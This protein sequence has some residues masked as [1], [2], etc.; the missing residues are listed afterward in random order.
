PKRTKDE[1]RATYTALRPIA[2]ELGL[3][4][5]EEDPTRQRNLALIAQIETAVENRTAQYNRGASGTDLKSRLERAHE[6]IG[7]LSRER[8]VVQSQLREIQGKYREA[9]ATIARQESEFAESQADLVRAR[10]AGPKMGRRIGDLTLQIRKG[11]A[12]SETVTK[13]QASIDS[14]KGE[15]ES[16]QRKSDAAEEQ[17]RAVEQ[18]RNRLLLELGNVKHRDDAPAGTLSHDEFAEVWVEYEETVSMLRKKVRDAEF[19]GNGFQNTNTVLH[20]SI[21]DL[22]RTRT[23]L[24]GRVTKLDNKNTEI[25]KAHEDLERRL[26]SALVALA[27]LEEEQRQGRP[28]TGEVTTSS[29]QKVTY[30]PRAEVRPDA[31]AYALGINNNRRSFKKSIEA[32]LDE[33]SVSY[34][35]P[36]DKVRFFSYE[37]LRP[38]VDSLAEKIVRKDGSNASGREV[39]EI[40]DEYCTSKDDPRWS[41][42]TW[43]FG[44][45]VAI[46]DLS[47]AYRITD[48]AAGR[49]L[50]KN[51]FVSTEERREGTSLTKLFTWSQKMRRAFG[52]RKHTDRDPRLPQ[53]V[54]V[55]DAFVD[56]AV[57]TRYETEIANLQT[58]V[59]ELEEKLEEGRVTYK[60]E[61]ANLERHIAALRGGE[62]HLTFDPEA[63][64]RVSYIPAVLDIWSGQ[65]LKDLRAVIESLDITTH[66]TSG[67]GGKAWEYGDVREYMPQILEAL[68]IPESEWETARDT[69]DRYF[70][71][72]EDERWSPELWEEGK[73]IQAKDLARAYRMSPDGASNVLNGKGVTSS[74]T[75]TRGIITTRIYAWSDTIKDIFEKRKMGDPNAPKLPRKI[76]VTVEEGSNVAEEVLSELDDVRQELRD[77]KET[78]ETRLAEQVER[79]TELEAVIAQYEAEPVAHETRRLVYGKEAE[80]NTYVLV[81]LGFGRDKNVSAYSG[82]MTRALTEGLDFQGRTVQ[83]GGKVWRY[84]VIRKELDAIAAVLSDGE[85]GLTL[86][87]GAL[88][89]LD[90]FFT[91]KEDPRWSPS[92]WEDGKELESHELALAYMLSGSGISNVLKKA[93]ITASRIERKG[94]AKCHF[95]TWDERMRNA[96]ENRRKDGNR[97]KP[98]EERWEVVEPVEGRELATLQ[99]ELNQL[100]TAYRELETHVASEEPAHLPETADEALGIALRMR[101]G[102]ETPAYIARFQEILPDGITKRLADLLKG[103]RDY[104]FK[105]IASTDEIQN[106]NLNVFAFDSV[107]ELYEDI[108]EEKPT[109][110]TTAPNLPGMDTL[111]VVFSQWMEMDGRRKENVKS[112]RIVKKYLNAGENED[113]ARKILWDTMTEPYDQAQ[114]VIKSAQLNYAKL[115]ENVTVPS[116]QD[117]TFH[118]YVAEQTHDDTHTLSIFLPFN[119]QDRQSKLATAARLSLYEMLP[120]QA[121]EWKD[122]DTP[123]ASPIQLHYHGK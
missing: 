35:E 49:V 97:P 71:G 105:Q 112:A 106:I 1:I 61:V 78:Y 57:V 2:T 33:L 10:E 118:V 80:A 53:E 47:L 65:R 9:E 34:R 114:S 28:A 21:A 36:L 120:E 77:S 86:A 58:T 4:I 66:K 5:V 63:R 43:E 68:R 123:N 88:A 79:I 19:T 51:K 119:E 73:E 104:V 56:D 14:L 122:R 85:S 89:T 24:R 6:S 52:A 13:L 48:T 111:K 3:E 7:Q 59:R 67:R 96:F 37:D 110:K 69:I 45:K 101:Y 100:K 92:F 23:Y 74:R 82:V 50:N 76:Y 20:S 17:L 12:S 30:D 39:T 11:V 107:E 46:S 29:R 83:G 103:E 26:G 81:A 94:K 115:T 55:D 87:E 91:K 22:E 109:R 90:D 116:L 72:E 18:S 121:S 102:Q 40:L 44:T 98:P 117:I 41:S 32:V 54:Y 25:K 113:N 31:I 38:H 99:D 84:E 64:L 108:E 42:S 62:E 27:E 95:Y 70:S 75:S 16:Y 60:A 93:G 8:D 15:K